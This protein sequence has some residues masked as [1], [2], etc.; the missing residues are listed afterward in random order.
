ML[1]MPRYAK[2]Q[3]VPSAVIEE[4]SLGPQQW[5]KDRTALARCQGRS[6][7]RGSVWGGRVAPLRSDWLEPVLANI[8][9]RRFLSS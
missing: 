8:R 9:N 3:T 4:Y 7:T 2:E 1:S 5:Q 6:D